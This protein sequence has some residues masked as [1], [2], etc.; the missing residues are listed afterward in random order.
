M[1]HEALRAGEIIR[2]IRDLVRKKL[3]EQR[4]LNLNAL[5]RVTRRSSWRA[6]RVM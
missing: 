5:V 3:I 1:A 4:P 6:R 2:R